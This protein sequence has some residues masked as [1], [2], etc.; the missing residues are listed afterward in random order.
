M[1]PHS[2]DRIKLPNAWW[3][4]F[5]HLGIEPY[6]VIRRARLPVSI[7]TETAEMSTAQYFA[8]WQSVSELVGDPAD[9]MKLIAESIP[10]KWPPSV[11]APYHA[12]DYRDALHRMARYKQLCTPE[13]LLIVEEGESCT[14]DLKWLFTELPVPPLLVE[15]T[16]SSL[17]GLGRHG[18]G[19]S[20]RAKLVELAQP[21]PKD[22]GK[23]LEDFFGC[24][25]QFGTQS[26]RLTLHR[27]DLDRHFISY[28]AELLEIV[29]PALEKSLEEQQS[30]KS[31]TEMV[32]WMVK[33]NLSG[34]RPDIQLIAGELGMSERTLQ[35]RLTD[36]GSSFKQLLTETRRE[37]AREFLID[38]ALDIKEVAFLLG[39]EDQNS[40]YR[41]FRLWEGDTPA[42]WRAEQLGAN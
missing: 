12:R 7:L 37:Q 22:Y 2:I 29:I 1:R 33:Q 5:R 3:T 34:G 38:P 27:G 11:L 15:I 6:D 8:I 16:L 36:E 19:Q 32:K 17:L 35:R 30:R 41:A 21:M 9:L 23:A 40:F 28:N 26:N 10:A 18:T 39:Y 14:I 13:L 20:L 4:V 42:N 25:I 31:L 24:G